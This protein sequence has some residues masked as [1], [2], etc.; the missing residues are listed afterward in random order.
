MAHMLKHGRITQLDGMRL[1][2]PITCVSQRITD[3]RHMFPGRILTRYEV[4]D[5]GARYAVWSVGLARGQ[6]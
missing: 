6:K 1:N 3:L 5:T 2:P 4:S